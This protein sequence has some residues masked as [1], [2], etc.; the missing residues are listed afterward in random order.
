MARGRFVKG[1]SNHFCLH[2]AHHVGDFLGTLVDEEHHEIGVRVVASDGV[3]NV[4]HQ[5][6][7]TRLGLC[8]DERTLSFADGSEEVHDSA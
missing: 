3:G 6:G 1:G 4:F 5:Q 2:G 8:H 7:L